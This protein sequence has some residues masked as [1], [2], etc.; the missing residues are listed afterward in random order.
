MSKVL[1]TGGAGFIGSNIVDLLI[2]NGFIVSVV[3]DLSTGQKKNLNPK[4]RFYKK[5]IAASD[6]T[7][8]FEKERPEYVVH[9]AAQ[10]NVR[11]SITDPAYDAGINILGSIN[12]LECCKKYKVKKIVYA[13]SGGAIYGEPVKLPADESHQIRPLCPY[14]ASKY[15]VENYL[16]IYKKNFGIDYVALRYSNVYGPRQDPLGEAG[17][18]A[19]FINKLMNR[20]QPTIFGDGKQTRDFIYVKDVARANLLAIQKNTKHTEY[21]IGT[22]Q[23]ISVNELY[24][25][26]KK[27]IGSD[28]KAVHGPEVSGEVRRI[29]LNIKRAEK[30][31]TWKPQISMENGLAETAKYFKTG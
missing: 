20:G 2:Q 1:V 29:Y 18:V 14:G 26:L 11:K 19:I 17:V 10:I 13:S 30:E 8:V 7:G 5:S 16:N 31:L 24:E 12:L 15:A 4:A 3:D 23:E 9:E 27:I 22:G 6:L 28:A 21:N 25:K